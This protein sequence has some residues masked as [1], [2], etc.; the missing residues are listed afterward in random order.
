MYNVKYLGTGQ[1]PLYSVLRSAIIHRRAWT[2]LG[3]PPSGFAKA[4]HSQPFGVLLSQPV[5]EGLVVFGS[6]ACRRSPGQLA[7][8]AGWLAGL[9]TRSG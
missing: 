9:I 6:E 7:R 8:P 4:F 2:V 5:H 1:V 3:P